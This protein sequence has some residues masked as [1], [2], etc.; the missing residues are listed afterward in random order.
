MQ[1]YLNNLFNT[2]PDHIICDQEYHIIFY[3][4]HYFIFMVHI[5]NSLPD[6]RFPNSCQMIIHFLEAFNGKNLLRQFSKNNIEHIVSLNY[7][8]AKLRAKY[9]ILAPF[10]RKIFFVQIK[11]TTPNLQYY[12]LNRACTPPLISHSLT[13]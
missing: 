12:L 1:R 7:K 5:Q 4:Y 2:N 11:N 6:K 3:F 10:V 9:K 8:S 13:I